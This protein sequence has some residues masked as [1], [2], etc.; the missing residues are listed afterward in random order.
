[1][2]LPDTSSRS[3]VASRSNLAGNRIATLD[4]DAFQPLIASLTTL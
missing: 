3:L 4:D 2:C 1:M